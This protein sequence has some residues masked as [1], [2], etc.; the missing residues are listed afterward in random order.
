MT[1]LANTDPLD[2]AKGRILIVD[3]NPLIRELLEFSVGSFGYQYASAEDGRQAVELLKNDLFSIV[4]TDMIMPH[5]DGMQ[6]L[7]HIREKYPRLGVI[8]VTGYTGTFSY[9][10]VIKAGA[11]DFISKP[12]NADELEAKISR[13]VRE[14]SLI[15]ELQ[16]LSMCDALTDLYNRR[17]F[18]VKIKEEVHRGDRQD[19]QVIL[20][21]ADVDNFKE[22]NDTYGH[23][24]GDQVLQGVSKILLRCTRENVDW[25]FRYGGDEFAIITPY[26][27]MNQALQV[28]E[29]ILQCFREGDF[30]NTGLSI[31]LAKFIKN[32]DCAIAED[33]IDLVRRADNALYKAK[34]EGRNKVVCDGDG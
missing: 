22:Y 9:T 15:R 32:E 28:S 16:H 8:V 30:G 24:A 11:S 25:N 17:Y 33:I 23:Q 21:L 12:F 3:D 1:I 14:Q 29:R 26:I 10:D 18:D 7:S 5:M 34:A 31:G 20:G 6:L 4:I 13:L 19:Y 2:G 27:N